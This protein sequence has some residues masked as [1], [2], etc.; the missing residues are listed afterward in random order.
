MTMDQMHF[1]F[2]TGGASTDVG[3]ITLAPIGEEWAL[4]ATAKEGSQVTFR[5]KIEEIQPKMFT[6][7][8]ASKGDTSFTNHSVVIL[9]LR[10]MRGALI[11]TSNGPSRS[12]G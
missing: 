1:E 6:E 2:I 8:V 4:W 11:S 9:G 5:C 12:P 10:T 3:E 7:S